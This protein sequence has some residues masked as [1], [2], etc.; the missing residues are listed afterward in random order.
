MAGLLIGS[1]LVGAGADGGPHF[2]GVHVL[3][4][5]GVLTSGALGFILVISILRSGRL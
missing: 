4:W 5:I 1:A 2:L 3:T